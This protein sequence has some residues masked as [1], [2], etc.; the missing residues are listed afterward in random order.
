[1]RDNPPHANNSRHLSRTLTT[2]TKESWQSTGTK[3][4]ISYV[5]RDRTC[6]AQSWDSGD[7]VF[8]DLKCGGFEGV[9]PLRWLHPG[10]NHYVNANV[11]GAITGCVRHRELFRE[12]QDLRLWG[13]NRGSWQAWLQPLNRPNSMFHR[14]PRFWFQTLE[15]NHLWVQFWCRH[16]ECHNRGSWLEPLLRLLVRVEQQL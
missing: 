5:Q 10:S 6:L 3:E 9:S 2:R 13:H 12:N 15:P 1:M 14:V 16:L 4:A 8:A 7:G 11:Y